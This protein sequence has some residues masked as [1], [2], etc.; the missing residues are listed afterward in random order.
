MHTT[1]Q[2]R[3]AL[4]ALHAAAQAPDADEPATA[5]DMHVQVGN[6]MIPWAEFWAMVDDQAEYAAAPA[7][8]QPAGGLQ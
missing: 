4:L 8:Q 2:E 5:D 7:P 6:R 1:P 3:S